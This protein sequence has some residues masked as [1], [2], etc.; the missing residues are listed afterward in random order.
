MIQITRNPCILVDGSS[1]LYRA[2]YTFPK[3]TNSTNEPTGAIHGVLRM[4]RYLLLEYQPSHIAVIFDAP[5]KTFRNELFP[6]YKANRPPMPDNLKKQIKPLYNILQAMGVPLLVTPAVEADDVI[7]TLALE[8]AI[9]GHSVLISTGDKDMA[10][11]VSSHITLLNTMNKTI[12]G[13]QEVY[14]KY[15]IPPALIIDLLSLV[16]DTADN[17][18]GVRGIGK[19]TAQILLQNLG[20]LDILYDNLK[21]IAT[22]SIRGAK[23]LAITLEQNKDIAYLSYKLATIKTNV[24]LKKSYSDLKLSMPDIDVLRPLCKR[25]ELERCLKEIE[26]SISLDRRKLEI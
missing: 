5:G 17:I 18:P 22:L 25:Y 11:L 19:K 12:L 23:K 10:Q 4:L 16:G 8:I 6:A 9:T 7:G 1:Y 2:Y 15:G 13:P 24:V 3:L 21:K 14:K 20:G 26:A